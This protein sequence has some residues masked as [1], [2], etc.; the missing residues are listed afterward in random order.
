VAMSDGLTF[1]F[2]VLLALVF[3]GSLVFVVLKIRLL[4]LLRVRFPHV[5]E[6]LGSP[7]TWPNNTTRSEILV[8]RWLWRNDFSSLGEAPAIAQCA[9]VRA[10]L[11]GSVIGWALV[12]VFAVLSR[13][14]AA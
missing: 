3:I 5:Y 7:E 13:V 6:S 1:S 4:S 11:I 10:S 2:V 8:L 9:K 14:W 12:F